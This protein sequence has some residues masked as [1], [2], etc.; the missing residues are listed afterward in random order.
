VGLLK[1]ARHDWDGAEVSFFFF[2]F[3]TLKPKVE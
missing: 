2:F 1:D 3:I